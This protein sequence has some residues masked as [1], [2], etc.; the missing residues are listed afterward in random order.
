MAIS[1]I[2]LED[3]FKIRRHSPQ[4]DNLDLCTDNPHRAGPENPWPRPI[5]LTLYPET[6]FAV[7][8]SLYSYSKSLSHQGGPSNLCGQLVVARGPL[9]KIAW[10]MNRRLLLRIYH[11]LNLFVYQ[12]SRC[13]A[14]LLCLLKELP[15]VGAAGELYLWV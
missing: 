3:R 8:H 15:E 4:W 7:T 6:S 2:E 1:P 10:P 14:P 12:L 13:L 11:F 5:T 9:L